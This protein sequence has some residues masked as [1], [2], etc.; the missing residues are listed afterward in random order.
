MTA[1]HAL[2]LS[3]FLA[4]T[5]PNPPPA[6]YDLVSKENGHQGFKLASCCLKRTSSRFILVVESKSDL[7]SE[8]TQNWFEP[9]DFPRVQFN[10]T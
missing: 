9:K 4:S 1:Y 10:L 6:G 2:S 7:N 8:I 5:I 3:A